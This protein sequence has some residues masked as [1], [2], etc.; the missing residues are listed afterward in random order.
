MRESENHT[1]ARHWS[2][3]FGWTI[4]PFVLNF[5][6]LAAQAALGWPK[7]PAV[8]VLTLALPVFLGATCVVVLYRPKKWDYLI[9]LVPYCLT[10]GVVVFGLT[11][12]FA[13]MLGA[14]K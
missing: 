3:V 12:V 13:I 7:L 8:G 11:I 4:G 6:V 9:L 10:Y 2:L 14:Q 1:R 5:L